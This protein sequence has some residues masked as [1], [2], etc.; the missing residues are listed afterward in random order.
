MR[1]NAGQKLS[2]IA[3]T[4]LFISEEARAKNIS[5]QKKAKKQK[6]FL[7]ETDRLSLR[8]LMDQQRGKTTK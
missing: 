4:K 7:K 3:G 2:L 6:L 1:K 8:H 5:F